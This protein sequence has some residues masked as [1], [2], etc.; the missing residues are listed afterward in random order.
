MLGT[1]MRQCICLRGGHNRVSRSTR[2]QDSWT[3]GTLKSIPFRKAAGNLTHGLNLFTPEGQRDAEVAA[4]RLT[5]DIHRLA[6]G[7]GQHLGAVE[8]RAYDCDQ[9]GEA[10]FDLFGGNQALAPNCLQVV[11]QHNHEA[12]TGQCFLSKII[13]GGLLSRFQREGAGRAVQ[14]EYKRETPSHRRTVNLHWRAAP[15]NPNVGS[16]IDVCTSQRLLTI[17]QA[18]RSKQ[19]GQQQGDGKHPPYSH[20][21]TLHEPSYYPRRHTNRA[22]QI[23]A[24]ASTVLLF[25]VP[26]CAQSYSNNE[27]SVGIASQT[28]GSYQNPENTWDHHLGEPTLSIGYTRNLSPSLAVEGSV[29]PTSQFFQT[30]DRV[31]YSGHETLA[32]GGVKAGWRGARWGFY[33]KTEAGIVSWSCRG[34]YTSRDIYTGCSYVTNF[35]L[36]YGGVVE[37]RLAGRYSLR[38]DAAHLLGVEFPVTIQS[39]PSLFFVS[40]GVT[41]QHADIRFAVVRSFEPLQDTFPEHAPAQTKWDAG[42]ALVMQPRGSPDGFPD[43]FQVFPSPALW[44]SWNF[45]RHLSWDSELIHSEPMRF[46][47]DE[48]AALQAGGR[49]FEALTGLKLGL[50]RDHMG[51]F[52]KLRGGTITFGETERALT[53]LSNGN[54][55]LNRGMFTDFVLDVGGV[56]EIYPSRHTILRF[57]AGSATIFYPSKAISSLGQSIYAPSSSHTGLLLSFGGG[58]RF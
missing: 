54:V 13:R 26:L 19:P 7:P 32:L 23:A 31:I 6:F 28:W 42:V 58:V 18:A 4:Q 17:C 30:N 40:P 20:G 16:A 8:Q 55:E 57:D 48:Y 50:R 41:L 43:I 37:R 45:S 1:I 56:Y 44:A 53:Q 27:I 15:V 49:S 39:S 2:N 35:A 51:Y 52:A 12:V 3:L 11:R 14:H 36:E 10:G 33:G 25:A 29:L 24:L 21:I 34:N 46:E 38:F 47:G 5:E 22:I 9:F